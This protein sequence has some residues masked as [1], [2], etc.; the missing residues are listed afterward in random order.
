MCGV[1][2]FYMPSLAQK[3]WFSA[4]GTACMVAVLLALPDSPL[5]VRA[6]SYYIL[7]L[8]TMYV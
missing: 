3:A 6:L 5:W 1:F 8:L 4:I 2:K 7:V